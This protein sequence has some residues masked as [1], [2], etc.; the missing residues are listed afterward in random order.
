MFLSLIVALIC[1]SCV[2]SNSNILDISDN[3]HKTYEGK[4][5]KAKELH[6]NAFGFVKKKKF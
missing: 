2:Y 5:A 6:T 4:A 1:V 3:W